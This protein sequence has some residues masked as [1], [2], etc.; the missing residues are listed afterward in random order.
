MGGCQVKPKTRIPCGRVEA[1][2]SRICGRFNGRKAG[3]GQNINLVRTLSFFFFFLVYLSLP[4]NMED[5]ESTHMGDGEPV[6]GGKPSVDKVRCKD[7][8][9]ERLGEGAYLERPLLPLA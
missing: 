8:E 6:Q 1:L 5:C 7:S 4:T 3:R 9:P 2:W